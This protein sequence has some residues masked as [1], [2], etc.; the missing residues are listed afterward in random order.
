MEMLLPDIGIGQ[1][2]P[3]PFWHPLK[4]LRMSGGHVAD[5]LTS[6]TSGAAVPSGSLFDKNE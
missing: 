4:E 1:V 5:L 3:G 6:V 2:A